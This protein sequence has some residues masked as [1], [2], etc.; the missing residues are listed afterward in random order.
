MRKIK[1]VPILVLVVLSLLWWGTDRT[2]LLNLTETL[3]WRNVLLQYTGVMCIGVM[4]L[5]MLLAVRPAFV[6]SFFGGLDKMYRLHKWLGVTALV[7]AI[8]HWWL[9]EELRPAGRR[10][11]GAARQA[12]DAL[13]IDSIQQFFMSQHH[14]AAGIGDFTFKIVLILLVL[15]L[16]KRFPY[17]LFF[18]S[19]RV[20]AITYLAL[21]WHSAVLLKFDYWSGVLGPVM[22]L[23]M[24]AGSVAAVIVLFRRVGAAHQVT[25][26]VASVVQRDAFG[27]IEVEIELSGAWGGHQAGQFAFLRFDKREGAHPFTIASAW[28]GDGRLKFIIKVLGDYTRTLA[29]SLQVGAE[30]RV[31]GP[32]GRFVFQGDQA[33][34]IW[35]GGGI[36]ITPFMARLKAL[37]KAPDGKR[38]DLFYTT[39]D[40]DAEMIDALDRDAKAAGVTL[41]VLLDQRDGLL[42]AARIAQAVPAWNEADLWFCGPARFGKTLRHDFVA[43]GMP[44]TRFHQELFE[45]R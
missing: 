16:I 18:K 45:M 41:H 28:E 20:L 7:T 10:P 9:N 4:S 1:L 17:R 22:A 11:H 27:I 31:E 6:E 25:G 38:I 37:A 35:V 2:D 29:T 14:T 34:Q 32:Y 21:V 23:L 39:R 30:V 44:E 42:N 36:G 12:L 19:H 26:K 15:A 24:A 33:R 8:L 5:A 40:E 3:A 43:M 13:P